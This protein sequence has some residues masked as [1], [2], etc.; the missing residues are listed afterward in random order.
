MFFIIQNG[1]MVVV[2]MV[3]VVS[4]YVVVACHSLECV[5]EVSAVRGPAAR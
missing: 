4:L 1:G 2:A 5:R 3:M